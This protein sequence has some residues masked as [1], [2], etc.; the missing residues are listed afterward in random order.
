MKKEINIT[1]CRSINKFITLLLNNSQT[2]FAKV[3]LSSS[4]FNI[5]LF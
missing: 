3:L 4:V 5:V 1:S 2:N